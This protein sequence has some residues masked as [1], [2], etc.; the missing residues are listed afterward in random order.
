MPFSNAIFTAAGVAGTFQHRS[1]TATNSYASPGPSIASDLP[2]AFY[3][4]TNPIGQMPP[5]GAFATTS[6]DMRG[7]AL[8]SGDSGRQL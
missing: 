3:R 5:Y 1:D 4:A 2:A 8:L 6:G 7:S